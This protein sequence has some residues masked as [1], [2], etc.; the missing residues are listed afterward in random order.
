MPQVNLTH[1]SNGCEV[2]SIIRSGISELDIVNAKEGGL[3]DQLSLAFNS[4]YV[5]FNRKIF[6]HSRKMNT[7]MIIICEILS[8]YYQ[9]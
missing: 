8:I 7:M 9:H 3:W 2:N 1:S 4:P 6:S 5:V